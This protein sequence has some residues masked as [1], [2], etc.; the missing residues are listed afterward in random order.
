MCLAWA[1]AMLGKEAPP[2]P[3]GRPAVPLWQD[4]Q[5]PGPVAGWV[6]SATRWQLVHRGAL[7]VGLVPEMAWQLE[8]SLVN[9]VALA[10]KWPLFWVSVCPAP[11]GTGCGVPAA[12]QAFTAALWR[13]VW[14]VR[15]QPPFPW[16][17][18]V[19]EYVLDPVTIAASK[20]MVPLGSW[21]AGR[22][23]A[24]PSTAGVFRYLKCAAAPLLPLVMLWQVVQA[25]PLARMAAL[26]VP[27]AWRPKASL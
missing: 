27:K 2:G 11:K 15:A 25:M 7:A 5:V 10:V 1:P 16:L 14:Q 22:P 13:W 26:C 9:V 19:T 24:V 18:L 4:R 17:P 8:Q 23:V 12:V 21:S 20:T 3:A 6:G